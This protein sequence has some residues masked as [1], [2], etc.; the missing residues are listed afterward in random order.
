MLAFRAPMT[1]PR[2]ANC[3]HTCEQL[4]SPPPAALPAMHAATT[5]ARCNADAACASSAA[6]TAAQHC[7]AVLIACIRLACRSCVQ[8]GYFADAFVHR[9][10]RRAQRRNPMI[11]RGGCIS[12]SCATP[13]CML[14]PAIPSTPFGPCY[15]DPAIDARFTHQPLR[16]AVTIN[17]LSRC[18]SLLPRFH[19]HACV[20][21]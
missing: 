3:E 7:K 10:V 17:P 6:C 16:P 13:I 11:N 5:G 19:V 9:F 12:T 21:L 8:R 20:P 18:C 14:F 15:P 4:G 1:M 2:S